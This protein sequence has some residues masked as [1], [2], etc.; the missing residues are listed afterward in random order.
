MGRAE[1]DLLANS[2][3]RE[4]CRTSDA[5]QLSAGNGLALLILTY[6]DGGARE[7]RKG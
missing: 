5:R 3:W 2:C 6:A 7:A 4:P 1:R